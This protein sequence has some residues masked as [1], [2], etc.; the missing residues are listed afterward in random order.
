MRQPREV[1]RGAMAP[2][3]A[4][5]LIVF[6]AAAA[7]AIDMGYI[8]TVRNE[9]QNAA[10][11]ASLAGASQLRVVPSPGG[12]N[13]MS[14]ALAAVAAA[15]VEAKKFCA[16]N[17]GG[18]AP[19]QLRDE[20]I[21]VGH[22]ASGSQAE[23]TPWTADQPFPNAVRVTVRRDDLANGPLRLFFAPVIG[24]PTWKGNVNATAGIDSGRYIITGF[25]TTPG[26]PNPQ[27]LP[28]AVHVESWNAFM[29]TGKS[30]DGQ[31]H[32]DFTAATP[33]STVK[34]P[35]N[36]VR[37]KDGVAELT[38]VYPDDTQPGNF[39]L[40][41]LRYTNPE[42]NTPQFSKW[43]LHGPTHEDMATFGV[44]G[45]RALP[46]TPVTIKGGPG[47]KSSL[48]PDM[49]GI[50]GQS[51]ILP[52]YTDVTGQGSNTYY[53]VAGFVG[54]TIVSATGRGSNIEVG[55]QP[56]PVIDPTAT[57]GTPG[58]TTVT[59]FVYPNSPIGLF[60]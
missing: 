3:T 14:R 58:T 9:M 31:V 13:E 21:V 24:N 49:N 18:G 2:L 28:L 56:M 6:L 5:L 29:K 22:L 51:R 46:S 7:F 52:L 4:V 60:R 32:D 37:S 16:L 25:Q 39:G 36:V 42:N 27:L 45:L 47:L 38:G 30:P 48:V 17:R 44:S 54:V 15:R 34:P 41:N 57:L 19:L 11:A 53:K 23:L 43:F 12:L 50:V 35:G 40:M 8:V 26:G 1:R 20:D 33:T 59:E 55:F 10:D